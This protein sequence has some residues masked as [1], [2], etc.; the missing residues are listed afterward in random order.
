[1]EAAS[2]PSRVYDHKGK[3]P[4]HLQVF[5]SQLAILFFTFIMV[6]NKLHDIIE[7]LYEVGHVLFLP[8]GRLM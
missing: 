8:N 7:F 4:T 6:V 5:C 2:A 3:Q 1:M